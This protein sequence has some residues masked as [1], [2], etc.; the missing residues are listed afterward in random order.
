MQN[1]FKKLWRLPVLPRTKQFLW[2]CVK[3]ILPTKDKLHG[4][5]QDEN[6]SCPF[7]THEPE[8]GSLLEDRICAWFDKLFVRQLQEPDLCKIAITAWC[9]WIS[10]CD[11]VFKGTSP[12]VENIIQRCKREFAVLEYQPIKN[13][14]TLEPQNRINL[15]WQPPVLDYFKINSDGSF[16][17]TNNNGGIGLIC[18]DFAGEHHGSKCFYLTQA[19]SPEQAESKALWEAMQWAVEKNLEKVIFELEAKLVVDAVLGVTMNVDW[20]LHDLTLDIKNLLSS[21]SFWQCCYVP[22]EKNKVAYSLSKLARTQGISDVWII[23]PPVEIIDQLNKD[24]HNVTAIY[25]SIKFPVS[26][27]KDDN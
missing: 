20:R 19:S 24:A 3:K 7:C 9:I 17:S 26:K 27:K 5:I 13:H 12:S 8:T 14:R 2:K 23:A 4:I 16:S 1:I 15:H 11:A 10:R 18:R 22:K 6:Y 21:H 25:S